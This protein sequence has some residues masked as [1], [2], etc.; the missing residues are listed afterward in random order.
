MRAAREAAFPTRSGQ[1]TKF[2]AKVAQQ[3]QQGGAE[4]VDTGAAL[5]TA[6]QSAAAKPTLVEGD[7]I[8]NR[9]LINQYFN[10]PMRKADKIEQ[11]MNQVKFLEDVNKLPGLQ[12]PEDLDLSVLTPEE[13][14]YYMERKEAVAKRFKALRDGP[15]IGDDGEKLPSMRELARLYRTK[16]RPGGRKGELQARVRGKQPRYFTPELATRGAKASQAFAQATGTDGRPQG[17]PQTAARAQFGQRSASAAAQSAGDPIQQQVARALSGLGSGPVTADKA[18]MVAQAIAQQ[19]AQQV[20]KQ[21]MRQLSGAT[22]AGEA[23]EVPEDVDHLPAPQAQVRKAQQ[24]KVDGWGI[25]RSFERDLGGADRVAVKPPEAQAAAVED[26]AAEKYT[27]RMLIK[28][29]SAIRQLGDLFASRWKDLSRPEMALLKNLGWGQQMWD[30][31]DTPAAKWPGTMVTAFVN[32]SPLQREAVRK[33]G[34]TPGEWDKRIQAMASGR[35][36]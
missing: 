23:F 28:D 6:K 32:L 14:Q 11:Q 22:A 36:A 30:T 4:A 19:V 25:P 18:G 1:V 17:L 15:R 3:V 9:A 35:N 31:K 16:R 34:F 13:K 20:A 5:R 7:P 33:L 29:Q 24:G 27:G 10:S 26:A 21:V 2:L 12:L 8:K